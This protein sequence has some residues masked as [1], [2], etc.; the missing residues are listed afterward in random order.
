[1]KFRDTAFEHGIQKGRIEEV[2]A[3]KWGQTKWFEIHEDV[4]GNSQD[5][6][7]GF[8]AEGNA[9]EIGISYIGDHEW[10]FHAMAVTPAW[11]KRYSE[12]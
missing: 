6:A 10:V 7:V 1:M 12:E 2:L 9:L 5:M 8:D 11:R 4:Q 3:N